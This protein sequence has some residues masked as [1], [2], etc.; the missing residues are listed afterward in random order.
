MNRYESLD[1]PFA[2]LSVISGTASPKTNLI[3]LPE[4]NGSITIS[5]AIDAYMACYQGKDESR[6]QRM[7]WWQSKIGRFTLNE[8][9][10]DHIFFAIEEL[11]SKDAR[12]YAGKDA[13]GKSIFKSKNKPYAPATINRYAAA[14]GALFTWCIKKR[15]APKRWEHP[16]KAIERRPENNEIVRFLSDGERQALLQA[17]RESKWPKLYLLTLLGITTGARKGELKRL[18]WSDINLERGEAYLAITKNGDRKTLPLLPVIIEEMM[19]FEQ[20]LNQHIFA[21]TRM[22]DRPYNHEDRWKQALKKAKVKEFRFHDLRHSCASF[23]AQ[24]GAT[25]LEIA[26]V[27]GQR[28]LT[29][30]KRYSHLAIK[31]KSDLV[32]RVMGDFR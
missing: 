14:I 11:A 7:T 31:H 23:L 29:T 3:A 8:V 26:D 24:S 21:S 25:L 27:L 9:D 1:V 4:R 28:N 12:Y 20:P 32:N 16:C 5:Q 10:E 17:C 2:S 13:D 15:I 18:R 30:T 6:A 19:K 22:P